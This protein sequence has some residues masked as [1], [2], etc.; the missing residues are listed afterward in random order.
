MT[1]T[2]PPLT[3]ARIIE[4]GLTIVDED[5]LDALSMRRL[6]RQLGV[7]AMSLYHHV[8]D[9]DDVVNGINLLVLSQL[10]TDTE[11]LDWPDALMAFAD[12]LYAAYLPRPSLARALT[13]TVPTSSELLVT[14]ERVLARLA[15]SRLPPATQVSAFRGVIA[16]TVGFVLVHTDPPPESPSVSWRG[17][18]AVDLSPSEM[19]HLVTLAPSLEATPLVDDFR[20]TVRAVVDALTVLSA[21]TCA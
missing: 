13:W 12:R 20:F 1:R 5:G 6:G 14:M 16:S 4:S 2:R 9:K 15:E 3:R 18:D 11:G 21:R 19:P 17:W 10:D 7:E 8:R